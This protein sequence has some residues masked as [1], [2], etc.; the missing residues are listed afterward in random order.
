MRS[1]RRVRI[2]PG[3]VLG[4]VGN[5]QCRLKVLKHLLAQLVYAVWINRHAESVSAQPF[6]RKTRDD[7]AQAHLARLM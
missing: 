2:G 7:M 4:F 6:R 5:R 1:K 3:R